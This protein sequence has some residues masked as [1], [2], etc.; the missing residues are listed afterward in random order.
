MI[1]WSVHKDNHLLL[2]INESIG[3]NESTELI[4]KYLAN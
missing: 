1:Q 3:L 4:Y 2:F